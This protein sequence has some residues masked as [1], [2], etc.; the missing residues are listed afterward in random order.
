M[1]KPKT[2]KFRTEIRIPESKNKIGYQSEIV[3]FG[4]CFTENIQQKLSW[5]QFQ[6]SSNSHGILFNPKA[7]EKAIVDCIVKRE[8]KKTDL[9]FFNDLWISMNHHSKFSSPKADTVIDHINKEIIKNHFLLK[10][11]THIIITLGTAWVYR[12]HKNNKFVANCH[13]IP[14][15]EY[16]KELLNTEEVFKI[17][18]NIINKINSFNPKAQILFTLS[19]VRHLKDGFTEN[20]LSKAVLTTAINRVLNTKNISY[21]PAYEIMMDDLRDYRFYKEDMVH[22]NETAVNYIWKL[23][24]ET[25]IDKKDHNLMKEI[26][27]IKKAL[28]HKPFN[29]DSPKHQEFNIHLHEKI[30]KLEEKH[31]FLHFDQK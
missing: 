12:Y 13:K 29:P 25:W 31:G 23:F 9:L 4:S 24:K 27:K 6:N 21:F 7:I 17:L 16:T 30:R 26:Y 2:M 15:K 3:L 5:F 22:P 18:Q 11:T 14:Q 8:Y 28:E 1:I 20:S 19:P 10:K